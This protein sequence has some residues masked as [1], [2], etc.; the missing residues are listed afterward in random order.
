MEQDSLSLLLSFFLNKVKVPPGQYTWQAAL[1]PRRALQ[2]WH[3]TDAG[4]CSSFPALCRPGIVPSLAR[5][6]A[7][8]VACAASV[9]R[10]LRASLAVVQAG[11]SA[12]A[13]VAP[14]TSSLRCR[15][16]QA[17]PPRGSWLLPE[18]AGMPASARPAVVEAQASPA[19]AQ[20]PS[21]APGGRL[22]R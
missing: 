1:Q 12:L 8:A 2:L 17:T 15:T 6:L 20:A 7:Q 16:T 5:M 13:A 11:E 9:P 4:R 22:P 18:L 21:G 14:G 10:L 19:R 3:R